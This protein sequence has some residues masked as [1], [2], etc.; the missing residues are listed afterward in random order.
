MSGAPSPARPEPADWSRLVRAAVG[1]LAEAGVEAPRV[2]AELLAADNPV[3]SG[4]HFEATPLVGRDDDVI[5]SAGVA[6]GVLGAARWYF[7]RTTDPAP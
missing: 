6:L 7:D 2:D 3:R 1:T 5:T 4:V